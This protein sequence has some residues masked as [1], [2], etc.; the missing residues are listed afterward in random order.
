MSPYPADYLEE[1]PGTVGSVACALLL[2]SLAA[3]F[4]PSIPVA[5]FPTANPIL[6]PSTIGQLIF[7]NASQPAAID[8]EGAISAFYSTLLA[9]Q[10]PLGKE[11]EEVLYDN[12]W[13][14]YV[15]S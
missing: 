9:K 6:R 10:Q 1:R 13:N 5:D 14:L 11:F 8:F 3:A 12:L 2:V 7:D 4:Q 15:R